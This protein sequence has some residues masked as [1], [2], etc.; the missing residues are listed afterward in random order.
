MVP[1][2]GS[3]FAEAALP[4]ALEI[5]ERAGGRV[6]VVLVHPEQYP[7]LM[8]EPPSVYLRKLV[9]RLRG[10]LG[11]RLSSIILNGPVAPA[12]ATHAYDIGADLVVMTTHGWGGVRRAWLGSVTDQLIRTTQAPV[13][14]IRHPESGS[15]PA[16]D[17]RRILIPLDGS[18][19]SEVALGPAT[20]LAQLWNAEI[21]L[22]HVVPAIQAV[23]E[24][25]GYPDDSEEE[26]SLRTKS[27]EAYIGRVVGR[28]RL[29]GVPVAGETV[30]GS[31]G[32]AESI[33]DVV[34]RQD[35][36]LIAMATHGRGG[37][38]R[39]VLGS[40]TDQVVRAADVP[41]LVVPLSRAARRVIEAQNQMI[42]SRSPL[43]QF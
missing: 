13:L 14:V 7:P 31:S 26:L 10:R 22:L 16:F 15:L 3:P 38:S 2:D 8:I 40:V 25:Y 27:A 42:G 23:D 28:A 37:V 33:L 35:F 36:N 18:L 17:I 41:L 1:V 9:R 5:A 20:A 11:R 32:V 24:G 30:D 12:L 21:S 4:Y 6:R 39:L 43:A 34:K 19:L 29:G